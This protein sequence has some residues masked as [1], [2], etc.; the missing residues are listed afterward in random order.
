ML[1]LKRSNFFANTGWRR[2]ISGN[3]TASQQVHRIV[4]SI[5]KALG[6]SYFV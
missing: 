5:G 2:K 6:M 1:P 3:F 4:Q